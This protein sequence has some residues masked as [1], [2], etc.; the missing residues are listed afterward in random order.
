MLVVFRTT[1]ERLRNPERLNLDRRQLEVCPLLE[2]EQRLRLLNFQNNSIRVIQN[3]ENLPN[4]I[5]LDLYNNK[6]SSLEGPL[7]AVKGL[8]VL[9][10]GKNKISTISNLHPLRKLDV[11]DLHS[12]EIRVIEGLDGLA[13]LRVLNL[14]G[15]RISVVNNLSS[16]VSLTE[17]NL[18]RNN[19]ESVTGLNQLPALQRVF[20]SHNSISRLEDVRCLFEVSY[21]IELSLDGNPISDNSSSSSSSSDSNDPIKYRAQLVVGMPGLRHLD[22]KRITEEE[23][24][25]ASALLN[26]TAGSGHDGDGSNNNSISGGSAT[27]YHRHQQ[28]QGKGGA[29][30]PHD[31]LHTGQQL[32]LSDYDASS[33]DNR[34]TSG[35]SSDDGEGS[36]VEVSSTGAVN[37]NTGSRD[38]RE[39]GDEKG[40]SRG[41]GAGPSSS[42]RTMTVGSASS[43]QPP[44]SSMERKGLQK[45]VNVSAEALAQAAGTSSAGIAH[46]QGLQQQ[47]QQ[48]PSSN[49]DAAGAALPTGRSAVAAT[50]IGLAALARAGTL[51]S[52]NSIFDLEVFPF[53]VNKLFAASFYPSYFIWEGDWARREG[54]NCRGR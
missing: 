49:L 28:L 13:D 46:L 16:L 48:Q 41:G 2:Q 20:L 36:V 3:L 35:Y 44:T 45:Y 50:S 10:A 32:V 26:S 43:Q 37:A 4:L 30:S 47:Q 8:R 15:N 34:K 18:R 27:R 9:M 51:L 39:A 31:G 25:S 21:L 53:V 7:S 24:A 33:V 11:L 42:P 17:L 1:E 5:F 19:I 14:A 52:T 12:N 29:E 38:D 6:I 40:S 54:T 23:R 22:L